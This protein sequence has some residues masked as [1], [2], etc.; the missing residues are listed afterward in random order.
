MGKTTR[1]DSQRR[2][3][4]SGAF[5]RRD[6]LTRAAAAGGVVSLSLGSQ[7]CGADTENPSQGPAGTASEGTPVID[8]HRHAQFEPGSPI[9][10]KIQEFAY[11]RLDREDHGTISTTTL[12]GITAQVYPEVLDIHMQVQGQREAGVTLGLLSFTMGLEMFCW[13]MFSLA[14]DLATQQYNDG[15]AEMVAEYPKDLAFMAMV[16][17]FRSKSVAECERCHTQLGAKGIAIGTS[18]DGEFLDS[19]KLDPLWEYAQDRDQPIWLH[20]PYAPIG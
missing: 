3:P 20:P 6:F 10:Q 16:N 13:A 2:K 17:P 14:D 4:R 19:P 1:G 8:V 15:H 18:W 12:H 7:G 9:E 11:K 5:T